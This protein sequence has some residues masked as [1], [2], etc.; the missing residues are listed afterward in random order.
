MLVLTAGALL[1]LMA[2]RAAGPA[3][4]AFQGVHVITAKKPARPAA[5]VRGDYGIA[6]APPA[7]RV[8]V[9]LKLPLKCGVLFDVQPGR[10][11]GSGT[12]RRS[13]RSRASRR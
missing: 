3:T 5:P 10:S 7:Q 4:I 1:G 13:C 11:C 8:S 12:R 9:K 2:A 6:L